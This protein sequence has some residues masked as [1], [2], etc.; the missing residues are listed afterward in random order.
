MIN[1]CAPAIIYLIFSITQILIDTFKGLYDSAF[2]KSI[3]AVMVTL[4]LNIL[5]ERNL[6]VVA[7]LIVFI[8]FMLMTVIVSM[9]LYIFGLDT[10]TGNLNYNCKENKDCGNGIKIDPS[11]NILIYDPEYNLTTNPVFYQSPNIIVRNPNLNDIKVNNV[12][13]VNNPVYY[14]PIPNGSNSPEYQS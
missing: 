9:L 1:L 4:L 10:A 8:P 11:G 7:W 2:M 14:N 3:V 13:N 12:N 6:S 5:C